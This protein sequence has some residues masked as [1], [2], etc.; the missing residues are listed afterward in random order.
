[1]RSLDLMEHIATAASPP[2]HADMLR[3]FGIPKSTL[4]G[5]LAELRSSGFVT[6]DDGRYLAGPRFTSLAYRGVGSMNRQSSI[7][8]QLEQLAA[9]THETALFAVHAGK[10]AIVVDRVESDDPI[11]YYTDLGVPRPLHDTAVGK[12]FLA[13]GGV[14]LDSLGTLERLTV[15]TTVDP[16][17]LAEELAQTVRRGY[18]LNR[19][20]S[21]MGVTAVAAPL[22]DERQT[23]IGAVSV[24]G[25]AHRMGDGSEAAQALLDAMRAMP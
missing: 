11:R 8:R 2:T 7:R 19:S 9:K 18:A 15:E 23:L 1:M 16:V 5:I 25:P 14:D 6:L 20:E 13:W 12:V 3:T 21:T 4:S 17:A 10:I 22:K 24:A